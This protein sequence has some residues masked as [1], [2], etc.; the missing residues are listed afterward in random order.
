ML[1]GQ[2][3]NALLYALLSR[4][5]D[6]TLATVIRALP[7]DELVT[8]ARRGVAAQI[9]TPA[10]EGTPSKP[11][12]RRASGKR[13]QPTV[14]KQRPQSRPKAP[15]DR[16]S[17]GSP[18]AEDRQAILDFLKRNDGVTFTAIIEEVGRL[19]ALLEDGLIE[20]QGTPRT[21]AARWHAAA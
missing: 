15:P 14:D 9:T 18:A 20:Q 12:K 5:D 6:T 17:N 8:L 3:I 16:P 11:K 10:N 1:R 13:R 19:N 7:D 21:P 2:P 4:V